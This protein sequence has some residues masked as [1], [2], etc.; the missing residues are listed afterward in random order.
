[1]AGDHLCIQA[2]VI[3][4]HDATLIHISNT[5]DRFVIVAEKIAAQG[6][7][8]IDL[9]R[10]TDNLFAR[11]RELEMADG[12]EGITVKHNVILVAATAICSFILAILTRIIWK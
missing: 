1:M 8:L 7:Q 9:R 11:V 5:L 6:E 4:T 12:K 3:G 10:D 2:K